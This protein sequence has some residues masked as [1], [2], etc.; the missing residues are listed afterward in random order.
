MMHEVEEIDSTCCPPRAKWYAKIFYL[1]L[2]M[3]HKL[4]LD[5]IRLPQDITFFGVIAG[6]LVPG[7][8]VYIRGPRLWGNLAM[9]ACAFL[10]LCFIVWLGYPF[11]NY[12]FGAMISVHVSGFVYYCRPMLQEKDFQFRI[13]FT[14]VTLVGVG[15]TFYL[16]ARHLV[17]NHFL[18]PIRMGDRVYVVGKSLPARSIQ[19]GDWVLYQLGGGNFGDAHEGG[20]VWMRS[21][22]GCGP[23]LAVAGD[24]VSFTTNGFFVNG[25]SY[26]LLPHMPTSGDVRVPEKHWFIWAE[27]GI[28][29]H[30]NTAESAISGAIMQVSLVP[31]ERFVGKPFKQWFWRKQ[32]LP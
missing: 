2:A 31:E 22:Y 18:V 32:I 7:L 30:G 5:R 12:A 28:S 23:V 16:P 11:G 3:R 25:I 14:V 15:L 29:G 10:F 17:Q 13:V 19:R 9:A 4:A 1:G 6:L 20:R 27:L 21:G 8:A 26:P 24:R